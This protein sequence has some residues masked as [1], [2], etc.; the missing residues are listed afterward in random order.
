MTSQLQNYFDS[1]IPTLVFRP[2]PSNE[3]IHASLILSLW[4]PVCDKPDSFANRDGRSIIA[5]AVN[6]AMNL[7]LDRAS[8]LIFTSLQ[9]KHTCSASW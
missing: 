6:M 3:S 9:N 7:G 5:N 1:I 4:S 8:V 2:S